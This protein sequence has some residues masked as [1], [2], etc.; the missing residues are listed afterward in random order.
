MIKVGKVVMHKVDKEL[1]GEGAD[2]KG[3]KVAG[4]VDETRRAQLQAHHTGTHII[5]ASCRNVLGPHIW[6]AGAK[7]T[8][9]KAHLDIT[10][11]KSLTRE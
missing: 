3:K 4:Q 6:Q 1:P 5:F 8:E 10:H 7:K 11:Y 9:T 2:L